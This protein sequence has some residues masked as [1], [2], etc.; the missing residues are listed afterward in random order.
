MNKTD[1]VELFDIIRAAYPGAE[2]FQSDSNTLML[3]MGLWQRKFAQD[4]FGAVVAALDRHIDNSTF[5]PSIADIKK[6]L[7]GT[8]IP[9]TAAADLW[10]MLVDAAEHINDA[11]SEFSYTAIESDGRTQGEHARERA[12]K[13]YDALPGAIKAT[14]GSYTAVLTFAK[15]LCGMND[16]SFSIRERDFKGAINEYIEKANT[17]QLF[18]LQIALQK[19]EEDLLLEQAKIFENLR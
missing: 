2:M 5:A 12:K 18:N 1:V 8:M 17:E 3:Q 7:R 4:D 16:T 9:S 11:R 15:E 19:S 10:E 6:E 14:M 13:Y